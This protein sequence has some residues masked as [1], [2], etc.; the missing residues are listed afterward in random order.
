ME[1]EFNLS[2]KIMYKVVSGRGGYLVRIY[3]ADIKDIKE[4]IKIIKEEIFQIV[5]MGG[6][7]SRRVDAVIDKLAGPK[8]TK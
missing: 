6:L 4:F 3:F 8:L 2:E 1:K 7:R 5:G